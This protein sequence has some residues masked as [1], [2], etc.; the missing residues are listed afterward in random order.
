MKKVILAAMALSCYTSLS[1]AQ[2]PQLAQVEQVIKTEETFNKL[3]ARK[4]IKEA[5]LAVADPEGIVLNR[6]RLV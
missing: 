3:V 4:G 2:K 1:L 5:F 6:R